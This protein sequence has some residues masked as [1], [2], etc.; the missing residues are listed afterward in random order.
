MYNITSYIIEK[1]KINKDSKPNNIRSTDKVLIFESDSNNK[2]DLGLF[3]TGLERFIQDNSCKKMIIAVE[4]GLRYVDKAYYQLNLITDQ[5]EK[6]C[7]ILFSPADEPSEIFINESDIF[8]KFI[9][10]L[11]KFE[12][13]KYKFFNPIFVDRYSAKYRYFYMWYSETNEAIFLLG[14]KEEYKILQQK[15]T[16]I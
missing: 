2:F 15:N 13:K 16:F 12:K 8:D 10:K 3:I 7:N 11:K 6:T 14:S 5:S 1:L 4:T 9:N